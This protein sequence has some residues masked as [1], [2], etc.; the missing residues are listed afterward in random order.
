MHGSFVR[1]FWT[2]SKACL[3]VL[4]AYMLTTCATGGF[5]IEK[6]LQLANVMERLK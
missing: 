5:G 4:Y 3:L 2:K 1:R 6:R